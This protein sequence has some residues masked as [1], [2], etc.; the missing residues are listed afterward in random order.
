MLKYNFISVSECIKEFFCK[1]LYDSTTTI[2]IKLYTAYVRTEIV[3]NF[4]CSYRYA[5]II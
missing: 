3:K 5:F 4:K 1:I 2:I